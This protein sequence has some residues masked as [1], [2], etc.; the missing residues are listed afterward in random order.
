MSRGAA[1]GGQ[2]RIAVR[3][4]SRRRRNFA[5]AVVF[6]L[7]AA[8]VAAYVIY[9]AGPAPDPFSLVTQRPSLPGSGWRPIAG[10]RTTNSRN[11][12][13]G[14]SAKA[15]WSIAGDPFA[16]PAAFET[17]CVYRREPVAWFVYKWQS[18][19]RVGGGDWPNF[20]PSV[21]D[22]RPTVPKAIGRLRPEAEQWEIGCG[23]GDPD[24]LCRVWVFRARYGR[25]LT[26][27]EFH[28]SVGDPGQ[29]SRF[30][31]MRKFVESVD[32]DVA[33]KL[34]SR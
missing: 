30:E 15:A 19:Y 10:I 1:L 2:S 24:G 5:A 28:Q 8:A 23:Y 34:R 16:E 21:S 11:C 33:A 27:L 13:H 32:S 12:P 7:F 9:R 3:S 29:G 18:L 25:V 17:V 22:G 31:T 14:R 6:A 26:V 4:M 20:D